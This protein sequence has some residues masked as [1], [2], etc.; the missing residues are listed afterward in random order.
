MDEPIQPVKPYGTNMVA[1]IPPE[2]PKISELVDQLR[3]NSV[4]DAGEVLS[5][6]LIRQQ[7]AAMSELMAVISKDLRT[8]AAALEN[9]MHEASQTADK[10]AKTLIGLTESMEQ[11][12][13]SVRTLTVWIVV[14]TVALLVA[15]LA[16]IVMEFRK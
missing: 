8:S 15:T 14:L 16:L 13:Q 11:A 2:D 12:H 4:R 1:A 3:Q 10:H 7:I 6:V 9:K 5:L